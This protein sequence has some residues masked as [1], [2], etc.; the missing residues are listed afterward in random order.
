M[1]AQLY[2]TAGESEGFIRTVFL[3][4]TGL[5]KCWQRNSVHS[6]P[7]LSTHAHARTHARTHAHSICIYIYAHA[8]GAS[9][10]RHPCGRRRRRPPRGPCAWHQLSAK[11]QETHRLGSLV[12]RMW[13]SLPGWKVPISCAAT[14]PGKL[15]EAAEAEVVVGSVEGGGGGVSLPSHYTRHWRH[16]TRH[17][18][19]RSSQG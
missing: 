17:S 15:T 6:V 2:H 1:R 5:V 9:G 14:L 13:C 19:R 7:K 3:G 12:V 11:E 16:R 18:V 4:S 10:A 8:A